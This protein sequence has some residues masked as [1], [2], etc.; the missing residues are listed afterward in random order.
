[1]AGDGAMTPMRQALDSLDLRR[2]GASRPSCP[3]AVNNHDRLAG[4]CAR[5]TSGRSPTFDFLADLRAWFGMPYLS[6]SHDLH[7]ARLLCD[8]VIVMGDGEIVEVV[9]AEAVRARPFRP[10]ARAPIYA[11]P[12]PPA[13][14][15]PAAK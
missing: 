6:A 10:H 1:M 13:I 3:I 7:V 11:A 9:A 8:R 5:T 14:A 2:T 15:A 12:P 4:S